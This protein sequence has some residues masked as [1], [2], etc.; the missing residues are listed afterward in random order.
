MT[1]LMCITLVASQ[2]SEVRL[3]KLQKTEALVLRV[4]TLMDDFCADLRGILTSA[5]P[6]QTTS[7]HDGGSGSQFSS[8]TLSAQQVEEWLRIASEDRQGIIQAFNH[9]VRNH[10]TR[11]RNLVALAR[12]QP[13][14]LAANLQKSAAAA[15]QAWELIRKFCQQVQEALS[16][17]DQEQSHSQF[18]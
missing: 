4:L 6:E 10:L 9:G 18:Q 16:G 8:V 15:E 3:A 13:S 1:P 2:P 5:G 12:I 11:P 7:E 17:A 14:E